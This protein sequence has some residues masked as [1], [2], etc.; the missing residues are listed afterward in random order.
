M[1]PSPRAQVLSNLSAISTMDPFVE[2]DLDRYDRLNEYRYDRYCE[3]NGLYPY[4]HVDDEYADAD[5]YKYCIQP[6][7]FSRMEALRL[8]MMKSELILQADRAARARG[9]QLRLAAEEQCRVAAEEAEKV[10]KIA[11]KAKRLAK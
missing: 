1:K 7:I 3:D 6:N 11:A 2:D 4:E 10:R 8:D 9:Y 5:R